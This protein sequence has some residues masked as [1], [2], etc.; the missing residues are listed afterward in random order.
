MKYAFYLLL[1]FPLLFSCN[2]KNQKDQKKN[3]LSKR[4]TTALSADLKSTIETITAAFAQQDSVT[5]NNYIRNEWGLYLVYR[6]GSSD[7]YTIVD[8]INFEQ[9]TPNYYQYPVFKN[10]SKL[11]FEVIPEFDCGTEK[12]NKEGFFCDTTCHPDILSQIVEFAKMYDVNAY[13]D[14]DIKQIKSL[15]KQSF[16][17]IATG[18]DSDSFIFHISLFEGKWYLTLIDRAYGGCDA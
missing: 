2:P 1:I 6:P 11:S 17:V 16:R 14:Q 8:G 15:E 7:T 18:D 3:D 5:I 9:P 10:S 13:E 4:D 12:W